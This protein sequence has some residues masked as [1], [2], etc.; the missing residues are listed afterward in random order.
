MEVGGHNKGNSCLCSLWTTPNTDRKWKCCGESNAE[1]FSKDGQ[2]W[3]QRTR[4]LKKS[5]YTARDFTLMH[6]NH[7]CLLWIKNLNQFQQTIS[8][9]KVDFISEYIIPLP[10]NTKFMILNICLIGCEKSILVKTFKMQSFI[11]TM[12]K[13][14]QTS[15]KKGF[16]WITVTLYVGSPFM[17]WLNWQ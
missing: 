9:T 13:N 3:G 11:Q 1:L 17:L 7:F 5:K 6:F 10:F 14:H 15:L 12:V 16:F 4:S 8:K 2:S